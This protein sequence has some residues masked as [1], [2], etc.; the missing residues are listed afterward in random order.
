M[1][2]TNNDIKWG[3]QNYI[4]KYN[5]KFQERNAGALEY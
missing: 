2:K 3:H 1:K 5:G 4:S